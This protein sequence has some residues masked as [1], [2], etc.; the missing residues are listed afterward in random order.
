[1]LVLAGC[2]ASPDICPAV[3]RGNIQCSWEGVTCFSTYDYCPCPAEDGGR[4][5][6]PCQCVAGLID[7]RSLPCPST[8]PYDAGFDVYYPDF[9]TPPRDVQVRERP[10]IPAPADWYVPEDRMIVFDVPRFH[11]LAPLDDL[12]PGLDGGID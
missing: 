8:C 2:K 3:V 5:R 11:D 1:L 4:L 7:C 9:G 6:R 10:D 12:A